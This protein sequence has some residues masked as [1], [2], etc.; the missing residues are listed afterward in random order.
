MMLQSTKI[1][2]DLR[3][4]IV[5]L[6]NK[7][8]R[9]AT[10]DDVINKLKDES[11]HMVD[12]LPHTMREVINEVIKKS[13]NSKKS[14]YFRSPG[15]VIVQMNR[16]FMKLDSFSLKWMKNG[17]EV[18]AEIQ[19]VIIYHKDDK[20][21]PIAVVIYIE[22]G[23]K[24]IRQFD[25]IFDREKIVYT[26]EE[27]IELD[28]SSLNSLAYVLV[29]YYY[30]FMMVKNGKIEY[31]PYV[32]SEP[33]QVDVVDL[34]GKTSTT[35]VDVPSE[36]VDDTEEDVDINEM[37]FE[38]FIMLTT[39]PPLSQKKLDKIF[40]DIDSGKDDFV[41]ELVSGMTTKV[42]IQEDSTPSEVSAND[43]V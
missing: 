35:T 39:K 31:A 29:Q 4:T 8:R 43:K 42:D 27:M 20:N 30:K 10:K 28:D 25:I 6:H 3:R 12:L 19:D 40:D 38:D 13:E 37:T 24:N 21:P 34:S 9:I 5:A 26:K 33:V 14:L 16:D 18:K 36:E 11:A 32:E 15:T 23:K 41:D 17:K 2:K 7:N 1:R 22:N